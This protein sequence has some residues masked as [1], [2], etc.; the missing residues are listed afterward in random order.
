MTNEQLQAMAEHR[1]TDELA[2]EVIMDRYTWEGLTTMLADICNGKAEHL[3][4]NW[5]DNFT[6]RRYE[7]AAR[8]FLRIK[9]PLRET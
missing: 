2:L 6:A 3:R 7:K 8:D 4:T 9:D 5:Q 1:R